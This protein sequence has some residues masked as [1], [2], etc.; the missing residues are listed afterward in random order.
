MKKQILA[1]I[2]MTLLL[3]AGAAAQEGW[4]A[5]FAV[6]EIAY[7]ANEDMCIAGYH[8]G[9]TGKTDLNDAAHASA[10][11]LEAGENG[12][13]LVSVDCVALCADTVD[14]IRGALKDI[15]YPVHVF[16]THCH[17]LPDTLG[18]WGK[19]GL[20]GKNDAY[21]QNLIAAARDAA[22]A[23]YAARTPGRL[24]YGAADTGNLQQDSRKPD[25]FDPLV[26]QLRFIPADGTPGGRVIVY[27]A[28]AESMRG[29]N[30]LFSRD[31]PGVLADEIREQ[32]GETVLFLS[33][34]AGGLVMTRVLIPGT[35]DAV[36]NRDRTGIRLAEAALSISGQ[37]VPAS[38][39]VNTVSF[40]IPL[41]NPVFMLYRYLGILGTRVKPG[42]SD[43][44]YC[45]TTE[46][47][48]LRL[49][50]MGIV[51]VPGEPFPELILGDTLTAGD[52]ESLSAIAARYGVHTLLCAALCDDEIGYIIPPHSFQV[53]EK[54]P[55]INR[56][57]DAT[58]EDHYEETNSVGIHAAQCI[59]DAFERLMAGQ[60]Q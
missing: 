47:T 5:G 16:A 20:D 23:A 10:V 50:E 22:R 46:M 44:G 8:N 3:T 54:L 59:A 48:L 34:P 40:D 13:I 53:D 32:T 27:A 58:G 36:R 24:E 6:R 45:L 33:G 17:A 1:V 31:F 14:R 18:L 11:C 38:L 12:V 60:T 37:T 7:P 4:N 49:G 15:P 43:T 42:R 56:I 21:M 57:R 41:D 39:Y 25:V 19:T 55:F 2:L 26:H 28:H 52:P 35:F 9:W 51:L 29:D 30:R